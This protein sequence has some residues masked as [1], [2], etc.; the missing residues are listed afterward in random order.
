MTPLFMRNLM[1]SRAGLLMV[2]LDDKVSS[3]KSMGYLVAPAGYGK[4]HLIALAVKNCC[5]PQLV[6]T[7]TY[8][9]VNSLRRK[10]RDEKVPNAS[11]QLTT[12]ASWALRL[13]LAF[14]KT[15]GWV[16]RTPHGSQWAEVYACC[17]DLLQKQFVQE[18]VS[19][20]Y[21]GIFVDE[22]QDCSASQHVLV[23]ALGGRLP[24]RVLGDPLQAIFE[25]VNV[26]A[27]QPIDWDA[28]V[29]SQFEC[30][31]ELAEPWRWK[32][33]GTLDVAD[34]LGEVRRKLLCGEPIDL[35]KGRPSGVKVFVVDDDDA[36][37]NRQINTCRWFQ[38]CDGE[39]VAAIHT[40]DGV[41]KAKCH[42][43]AKQCSGRFS[44][45]EEVEGQR[46][47]AFVASYDKKSGNDEKLL[48]CIEFA[49]KKCM[50]G[51][52]EAL[53]A[54]T[55]K[56]EAVKL[57]AKTRNP[58]LTV[59][60]NRFLDTGAEA[61][62]LKFW[63]ELRHVDGTT[64]YARDL[65][66]RLEKVL[67]EAALAPDLG[68]GAALER[69]QSKFRHIGR[70]MRFPKIIG[71][72]LLLKGLEFDHSIVLDATSLTKKDLYV[73]LTRARKSI[74]IISRNMI[75]DPRD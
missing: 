74:T 19:A 57:G 69:F 17:V 47:S 64:L 13:C 31:G 61:D 2:S 45:I 8:A 59:A 12:I 6:L 25:S 36:L 55:K 33:V 49:K 43:L 16:E 26:K 62:L 63:L 18:I 1:F 20:S 50:S 15:S 29:S 46:L 22:Y 44:S 65:F 75:L 37:R 54:G 14:P 73:A 60:A 39:N 48:E 27:D 40:G 4:S 32:N 30:L 68:L 67:E 41:H 23:K 56:G 3:S 5:G 38:L 53:S 70:P 35:S 11:Y 52:N 21:S 42:R 24:L 66:N 58:L 7:H 10:F 9:G 34:W 28:D 51:V 71:T 72:T